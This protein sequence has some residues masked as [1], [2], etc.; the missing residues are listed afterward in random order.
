MNFIKNLTEWKKFN[1]MLNEENQSDGV[2]CHQCAT[3]PENYVKLDCA[4]KFCLLC[5]AYMFLEQ[6][7][8]N[9][10]ITI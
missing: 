8:S 10:N 1:F 2:A 3:I 9:S 7:K 4:H 6:E 5:L